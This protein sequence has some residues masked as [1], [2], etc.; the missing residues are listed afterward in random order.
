MAI[1]Y[2]IGR[3]FIDKP[4]AS[5]IAEA[6]LD[7]ELLST[8]PVPHSPTPRFE[9]ELAWE[10]DRSG[11]RQYRLQRASIK[12]QIF[13]IDYDASLCSR[14]LLGYIVLDVRSATERKTFKWFQLLNSK[15]RPCPEIYCGLY[16]DLCS[17]SNPEASGDLD[18]SPLEVKHF[19]ENFENQ[20]V[21]GFEISGTGSAKEC[22]LISTVLVS[23]PQLANLLPPEVSQ[24]S[25]FK[26]AL[27]FLNNDLFI[28]EFKEEDC[29][30]F[31]ADHY[32]FFIR[33]EY[34][35]SILWR[36]ERQQMLFGPAFH[37]P[38][39]LKL[40]FTLMKSRSATVKE[41][42]H[43]LA[44]KLRRPPAIPFLWTLRLP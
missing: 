40:R 34:I 14:N 37:E 16:I 27:R 42:C 13:A 4:G 19:V 43:P 9:Q 24:S 25:T 31:V 21:G 10:V 17:A 32:K 2:L 22:Y 12:L 18:A 28:W 26:L 5:V 35:H 3:N 33:L 11:L 23:I 41:I 20:L 7:R 6:K 30:E 8:D 44:T 1:C 39:L 15:L 38:T 29:T 36:L